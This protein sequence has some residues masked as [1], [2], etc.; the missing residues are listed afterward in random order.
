MNRFTSL[1]LALSLVLAG[2][3]AIAQTEQMPFM[4]RVF[5]RLVYPP[6]NRD[7]AAVW[8]PRPRW[9]VTLS[10]ELRQTGVSQTHS[11]VSGGIPIAMESRL[12][13]RLYTG[14]GAAF[15]FSCG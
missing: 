15:G 8:Q 14:A 3:D 4:K 5:T 2:P 9:N 1:L 6:A 13:E 11:T 10:G 7:T 12:Q